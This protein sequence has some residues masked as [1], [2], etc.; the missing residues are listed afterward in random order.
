MTPKRI[1]A[2]ALLITGLSIA[3]AGLLYNRDNDSAITIAD[4][5]TSDAEQV[6]SLNQEQL[7]ELASS[8]TAGE[9]SEVV[10]IVENS[11]SNTVQNQDSSDSVVV[12]ADANENI[13][14]SSKDVTVKAGVVVNANITAANGDVYIESGAVINGKV[15]AANGIIYVAESAQVAEYGSGDVETLE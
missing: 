9:F 11:E 10:A 1:L 15:T 14:S 8:S 2:L 7:D 4:I 13:F 12:G 5:D 3:A 6:K